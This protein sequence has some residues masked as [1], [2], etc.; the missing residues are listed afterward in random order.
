MGGF[1][2]NGDRGHLPRLSAAHYR[3]YAFV[4]WTH[5]ADRRVAAFT[6]D[7]THTA[8]RELLLHACSRFSLVCPAYCMMPDHVHVMWLG[9]AADADQ[10]LATAFLRRHLASRIAPATL[11]KQPYDHVLREKDRERGA[12]AAVCHY[13]AQ[14]PV[15]KGLCEEWQAFRFL[16]CV[17]PGYPELDPRDPDFWLRFWRMYRFMRDREGS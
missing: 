2:G 1:A 5:A 13:I 6:T 11:Q 3:A 15:R 16:G 7:E 17:V 9:I 14:N 8:L 12:F 4:H 10:R